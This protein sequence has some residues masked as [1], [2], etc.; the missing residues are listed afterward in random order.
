MSHDPALSQSLVACIDQDSGSILFA[1]PATNIV[2][3]VLVDPLRVSLGFGCRRWGIG[4][5]LTVE[6][7]MRLYEGLG[8][9]LADLG[10]Q[11]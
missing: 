3:P 2:A 4:L 5:Y 9:L 11:G 8:R 7:A 6:D 1:D 10:N